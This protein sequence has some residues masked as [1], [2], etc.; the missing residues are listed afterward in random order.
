MKMKCKTC[1]FEDYF[2]KREITS[3]VIF[4]EEEIRDPKVG[5]A[6]TTILDAIICPECAQ[7][8]SYYPRDDDKHI[9][10]LINS[11][12]EIHI[13]QLKLKEE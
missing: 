3:S 2:Y 12:T 6:C 5:D 8:Y 1:G 7:V 4:S 10:E 13:E 9:D 11:E